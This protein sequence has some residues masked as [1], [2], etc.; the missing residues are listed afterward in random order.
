MSELLT[1]ECMTTP[2]IYGGT[3]YQE[4]REHWQW[5]FDDPSAPDAIDASMPRDPHF[6]IETTLIKRHSVHPIEAAVLTQ[7][8][9][10]SVI[11]RKE[12]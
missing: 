11:E 2:T 1:K 8:A 10:D 5:W 12:Q 4:A 7:F 3:P 9:L 6:F